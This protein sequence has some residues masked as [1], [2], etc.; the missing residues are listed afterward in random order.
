[1]LFGSKITTE[2]NQFNSNVFSS[3]REGRFA[4]TSVHEGHIYFRNSFLEIKTRLETFNFRLPVA[5]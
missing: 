5:I 2:I 4:Y 3:I 1:M